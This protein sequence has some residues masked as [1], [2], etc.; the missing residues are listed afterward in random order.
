MVLLVINSS[1]F[2]ENLTKHLN[3]SFLPHTNK[4][5]SQ[6][7]RVYGKATQGSKENNQCEVKTL[8][9]TDLQL[10]HHGFCSGWHDL[11]VTQVSFLQK[12]QGS[13]TWVQGF[14]AHV[15]LC[16]L[17]RMWTGSRS[18]R[19]WATSVLSQKYDTG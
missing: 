5:C 8:V 14:T 18:V 1:Y 17:L 3:H 12:I 6:L 9:F 10:L 2:I 7:M 4:K 19:I 13:Y 16:V 11:E 15:I